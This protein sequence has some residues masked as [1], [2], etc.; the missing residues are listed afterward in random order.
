MCTLSFLPSHKGFHLLMNRDEQ[1]LRP[2]GIPPA[3]HHCDARAAIYPSE[4]TGGTWIG[5]ND[6]GLTFALINWYSK[7]QLSTPPAFSRGMIIPQLLSQRTLDAAGDLFFSLPHSR[8]NPYRLIGISLAERRLQE[9]C[10]CVTDT[11][12]LALSWERRHWFSSGFE[13]AETSRV[14]AAT[15][16]EAF[17]D[18]AGISL[19][20]VRRLQ[21]SHLPSKG[22]SSICMHRPDACTVSCTELSL[23]HGRAAMRHHSGAPCEAL[24]L[25]CSELGLP[26]LS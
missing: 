16:R 4:P 15:C 1:R 11:E 24:D 20:S 22:P 26:I 19:D 17:V 18:Y 21:S 25:P 6:L 7:P 13:E 14:R 5:S 3:I 9:W 2:E 23:T 10:S 8:L 12:L